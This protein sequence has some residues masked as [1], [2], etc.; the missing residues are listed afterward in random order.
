M[1]F[2][3]PWRWIEDK[4]VVVHLFIDFHDSSFVAASV[5]IVGSG[6]N[7]HDSFFMRPVVA[8]N[9]NKDDASLIYWENKELTCMTS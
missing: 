5:A 1:R 6:E 9:S 4:E 7:R 8:L 3:T 2:A